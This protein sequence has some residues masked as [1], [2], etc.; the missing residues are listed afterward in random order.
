M[1]REIVR[2]RDGE[3]EAKMAERAS[4]AGDAL[5]NIENPIRFLFHNFHCPAWKKP[6]IQIREID[7]PHTLG[8]SIGLYRNLP[9]DGVLG[10]IGTRH[11][12][13]HR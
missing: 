10:T 1:L 12:P 5:S 3:W 4:D 8:I 9:S 7:A 6:T 13:H 2:S 11:V